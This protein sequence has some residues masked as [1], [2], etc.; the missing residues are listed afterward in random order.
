M[1]LSAC[2]SLAKL[3]SSELQLSPKLEQALR[4]KLFCLPYQLL[5]RISSLSERNNCC[6]KAP[7]CCQLIHPP[8]R[9]ITHT[10]THTYTNTHTHTHRV[11]A[12]P[13]HTSMLK[14]LL[15]LFYFQTCQ[16]LCSKHFPNCSQFRSMAQSILT[17]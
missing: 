4:F 10:H 2:S 5:L 6:K 11:P 17:L 14:K 16:D 9:P 12:D 15:F 8:T 13:T 1:N 3:L 7:S